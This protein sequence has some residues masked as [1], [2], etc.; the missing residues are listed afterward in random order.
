[1]DAYGKVVLKTNDYQNNWPQDEINFKNVNPVY[2]YIITTANNNTK[3]GS[4]TIIK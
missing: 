3:K 4:I 1:M 2:Y